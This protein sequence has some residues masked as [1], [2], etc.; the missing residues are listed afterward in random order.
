MTDQPPIPVFFI[1]DDVRLLDSVRRMLRRAAVSWPAEFFDDPAAAISAIEDQEHALIVTD[2][3]MAGIDGLEV[4]QRAHRQRESTQSGR[5][6]ILLTGKSETERV[7]EA[8]EAGADDY[9]RKPFELRELLARIQ[10][11]LRILHLQRELH[12]ANRLLRV[13]AATDPLTG[14]ATRRHANELLERELDRVWRGMQALSVLLIDLDKFKAINDGEGHGA[15]DEVLRQVALRV[16]A[17]CR[18]YDTVARWGGDEL[19]VI[20]PHA[21][22]AQ[23]GRV[24]QRIRKDVDELRIAF[25]GKTLR[26]TTSIGVACAEPGHCETIEPLVA[27]ADEALYR[28]KARGGNGVCQAEPRCEATGS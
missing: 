28:V 12:E 4:C 13:Q 6:V 5:Y 2:W 23:A 26:L 22:A 15:G 9:I 20:C 14:L 3:H 1:D 21:A 18:R 10:V 24:A 8:L 16:R 27:R 7:V 17:N 11:G 19:L 25:N